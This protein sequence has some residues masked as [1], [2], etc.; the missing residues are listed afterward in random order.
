[1]S[2][3][4]LRY[5]TVKDIFKQEAVTAIGRKPWIS[6]TAINTIRQIADI[7]IKDIMQTAA[8]YTDIDDK[9]TIKSEHV[10]KALIAKE[11][12]TLG[13]LYASVD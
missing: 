2:K 8:T 11:S 9:K 12:N 10:L 13:D 3:E 5:Q 1:M 4:I 6:D 7:Y